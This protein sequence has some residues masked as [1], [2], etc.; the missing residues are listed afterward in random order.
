MRAF[1]FFYRGLLLASVV[2]LLAASCG[3][4]DGS[5]DSSP[6]ELTSSTTTTPPS[7]EESPP[8]TT[9]S[10][11]DP[12][13]NG[14]T[15]PVDS[16]TT[17]PQ[18]T[19]SSDGSAGSVTSADNTTATWSLTSTEGEL[20]FEASVSNPDPA[21]A[22]VLGA[23]VSDCL[24]PDGGLDAMDGEGLSVSVGVLD[25]ERTFGYLWGRVAREVIS[26][27]I[28]HTDGSQT[29]IELIDGPTDVQLFAVVV[30]TTT[31]APVETLDAVS[32]TQIEG[33][34]PIRDFLQAGPTYP[35]VPPV[36][37]PDAELYP[38]N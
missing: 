6:T 32:G 30:D 20:C 22:D 31:L 38:T 29:S 23:G 2:A 27:T 36:T 3:D 24:T 37:V 33:S 16:T 5:D 15:T 25:G 8:S 34:A 21:E 14:E 28:E 11:A 7:D 35:T 17:D 18:A 9:V 12:E 4:D 26:L 1:H 10:A 13:S 19:Q